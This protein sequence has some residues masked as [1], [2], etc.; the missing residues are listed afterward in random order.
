LAPWGSGRVW[1]TRTGRNFFVLTSLPGTA[2][3]LPS[4]DEAAALT[5]RQHLSLQLPSSSA[6]D[7]LA[8]Q[9]EMRALDAKFLARYPGSFL[10]DVSVPGRLHITD[11]WKGRSTATP[12]WWCCGHGCSGCP[13]FGLKR[14]TTNAAALAD[15]TLHSELERL[16]PLELSIR[17]TR[18]L[19]PPSA[20]P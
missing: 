3:H 4:L 20:T 12:E 15:P 18:N 16:S 13:L 19:E 1:S 11:A 5:V 7:R 2:I 8:I 6:T 14:Y 10:E 9:E 17:L